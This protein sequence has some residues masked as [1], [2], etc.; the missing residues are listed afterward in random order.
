MDKNHKM[1]MLS[2]HD[3]SSYIAHY[4]NF[5]MAL[6]GGHAP[7]SH[8]EHAFL[9]KNTPVYT[10]FL[11]TKLINQTLLI[12]GI[13]KWHTD[14]KGVNHIWRH[15]SISGNIV[16]RREVQDK[17]ESKNFL[18]WEVPGRKGPTVL[19]RPQS[20]FLKALQFT[21]LGPMLMTFYLASSESIKLQII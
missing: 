5:F 19:K 6:M 20:A 15:S 12:K 18:I 1:L 11:H 9:S 2:S 13:C 7:F 14:Y 4:C 21:S 3:Q 16:L 8:D 17:W 10:N